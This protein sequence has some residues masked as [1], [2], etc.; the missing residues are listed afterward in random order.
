LSVLEQNVTPTICVHYTL[1]RF[2]R[3][4]LFDTA[5]QHVKLLEISP[6][7]CLRFKTCKH[8]CN[9]CWISFW[10]L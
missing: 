1:V 5:C 4:A 6:I 8:A 7:G 2:C 10:F 3:S 9:P